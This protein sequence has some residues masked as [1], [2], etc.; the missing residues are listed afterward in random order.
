MSEDERRALME[1]VEAQ[2]LSAARELDFERAAKLRDQL[3]A[4]RG[5]KVVK[6]DV[7]QRRARPART[8]K[9]EH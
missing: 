8:R 1:N 2:M 5:E 7:Q 6:Q 4:L 3:M 9:S